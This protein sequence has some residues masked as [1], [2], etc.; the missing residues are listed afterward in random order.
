MTA[1]VATRWTV[2]EGSIYVLQIDPQLTLLTDSRWWTFI[3]GPAATQSVLRQLGGKQLDYGI[4]QISED[5][6][7][8]S[9]HGHVPLKLLD[10]IAEVFPAWALDKR[11]GP[12]VG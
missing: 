1:T 8:G 4:F 7:I 5:E 9:A 10:R 11:V 6:Y 3:V 12:R 2:G